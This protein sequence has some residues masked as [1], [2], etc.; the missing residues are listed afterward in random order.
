MAGVFIGKHGS[1]QVAHYLMHINQNLSGILWVKGNRLNVRIDFRPLLRPV[2]ADF[3]RATN[4][5]AFERFGP[6]HFRRHGGEGGVNIARVESS[7]GRA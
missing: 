2:S 4:K 1:R 7:I 3:L 6:S 5:T